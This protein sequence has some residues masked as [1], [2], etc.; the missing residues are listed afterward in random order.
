M[1]PNKPI[2]LQVGSG[3][4]PPVQ[5]PDPPAKRGRKGVPELDTAAVAAGI[6][7]P[8]HS[9][10]VAGALHCSESHF[11]NNQYQYVL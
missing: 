4:L 3:Q 1:D 9:S 7:A 11:F 5:L 10:A 6:T 2:Y 8:V